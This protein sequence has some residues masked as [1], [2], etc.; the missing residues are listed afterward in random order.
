MNATLERAKQFISGIVRRKQEAQKSLW[1]SYDDLVERLVSGEE[2]DETEF[3]SILEA[4]GKTEK[5]LL[6]DPRLTRGNRIVDFNGDVDRKQ[7]RQAWASELAELRSLQAKLPQLEMAVE[8]AKEKLQKAIEPLQQAV[9]E[10]FVKHKEAADQVNQ[11]TNIEGYLYQTVADP[12]ILQREQEI[13]VRRRELR[14]IEL[15]INERNGEMI[16][17]Y[18]YEL[19]RLK[20][21]SAGT[22][23]DELR[24]SIEIRRPLVEKARR[25]LDAVKAEQQA[26][27]REIEELAKRKLVP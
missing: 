26:L 18:E 25:E 14:D 1:K 24:Q 22:D 17:V 2:I 23:C 6:G 20:K 13:A 16:K 10:A 11:I 7:K 9:T 4:C 12:E 21:A 27:N 8:Q 3:E 15:D 19:S 5:D